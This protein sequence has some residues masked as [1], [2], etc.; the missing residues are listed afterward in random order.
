MSGRGMRIFLNH[1][2]SKLIG[3]PIINAIINGPENNLFTSLYFILFNH[4]SVFLKNK[5]SEE[6]KVEKTS[7]IFGGIVLF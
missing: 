1:N 6:I 4:S 5:Y 7:L 3:T 2:V